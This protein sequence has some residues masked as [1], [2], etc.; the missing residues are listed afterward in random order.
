MFGNSTRAVTRGDAGKNLVTGCQVI[1][2]SDRMAYVYVHTS[3][4]VTVEALMGGTSPGIM[5]SRDGRPIPQIA[6]EFLDFGPAW[7]V[8][9]AFAEKSGVKVAFLAEEH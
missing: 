7:E 8:F 4:P 5:V 1:A 2:E 6:I 3:D 9:S